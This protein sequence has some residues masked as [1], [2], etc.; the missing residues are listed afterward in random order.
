MKRNRIVGLLLAA[1]TAFSLAACG[2]GEKNEDAGVLL[3]EAKANA[4]AITGCT[5]VI[6]NTLEF[7]VNG[8]QQRVQTG[9]DIVYQ[10][11]PFALKSTQTSLLGGKTSSNTVYNVTDHDGIWF[12]AQSGDQ[13]QKT[14]AGAIDTT[15]FRQV[16]ILRLLNSVKGQKYVR[17]ADLDFGKAYKL[18]LTF[19]S[20]V[21]RGT[22]ENIVT[23]A[24]IGEGS[25]TVVQT[26][27]DS[28][29]DLYGYGYIDEKTN[30]I[31]KLELDATQS[32]NR[33][34]QNIDGSSAKVVVTKCVTEGTIQNIGKQP[35]VQL[36]AQ[37]AAAAAVQAQG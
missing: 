15:P 30:Q 1:V 28:A 11:E 4:G 14:P 12:Y 20:E 8:R 10:A 19:D 2:G 21:L 25:N 31:V 32:V 27:L 36:P 23:A 6:R 13:W 24:G 16:D 29:G 26:L 3:R 33:I 18:E 9:N 34:F 7:S 5:A 35:E 17:E 37:A 22:V